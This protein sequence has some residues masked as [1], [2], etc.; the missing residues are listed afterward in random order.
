MKNRI[1]VA[2]LLALIAT[3][4]LAKTRYVVEPVNG[5]VSFSILKW[6]VFKEEG[7]FREFNATIVLTPDVAQSRVDFT[8]KAASVDTKNTNRDG[9]LRSS[10]FFDAAKY[11][12]LTFRS[13]SVKP[14]GK[15]AADVTGDLTIHGVTKRITVP[16]R[17]VGKTRDG[18]R[19]LAGFETEFTI[20][21]RQFN[22]TGG[23]WIAGAPAGILG[24]DVTIRI[25]A[26]GV[27]R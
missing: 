15:D 24:N 18:D 14:R 27:S 16:V 26:G 3:A 17:L 2:L 20:D 1:A 12:E 13:T 22:V 23:R 8:V 19:E 5:S 11:P 4:C 21:R 9:T 10:D 25:V 6:G 7:T